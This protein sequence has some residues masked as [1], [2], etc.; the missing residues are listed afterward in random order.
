MG[1]AGEVRVCVIIPE[2][3][4]AKAGGLGSRDRERHGS[5]MAIRAVAADNSGLMSTSSP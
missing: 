3:A 5:G 4:D 2:Q 1:L